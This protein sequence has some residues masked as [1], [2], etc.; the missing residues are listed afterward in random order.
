MKPICAEVM[1]QSERHVL[2]PASA[3]HPYGLLVSNFTTYLLSHNALVFRA[4][5]AT[6]SLSSSVHFCVL[7]NS[8]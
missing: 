2:R 6:K 5:V 1:Y 7:G 4:E 8:L 3:Y